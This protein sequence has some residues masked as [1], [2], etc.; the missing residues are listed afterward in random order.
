MNKFSTILT[1]A[2]IFAM[3]FA[4]IFISSLANAQALKEYQRPMFCSADIEGVRTFFIEEENMKPRMLGFLKGSEG[5]VAVSL[6]ENE[7]EETFALVEE[8]V[9]GICI[10]ASGG[11]EGY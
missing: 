11:W 10:V 7:E 1:I 9:A 4:I 3:I 5:S 2:G 6:Y 8:T